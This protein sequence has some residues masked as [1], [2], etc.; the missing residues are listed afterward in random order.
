MN[1]LIT[2]EEAIHIAFSPDE[3]IHTQAITDADIVEAEERFLRPIMGNSLIN[4]IA[5]GNYTSLRDDYVAPALAQWSR[6]VAQPLHR[7][8]TIEEGDNSHNNT[9]AN[10]DHLRL[11][12]RTLHRKASTLS[13]R[14]STHLNAHSDE[15]PEYNPN[16]NILNHCSIHG[17]IIQIL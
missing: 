10:N 3:M 17:D 11:L 9:L 13:R 6:Y 2:R 8:R 7:A 12:L 4:A 15:Y 5:D 1:T 14:L 16:N